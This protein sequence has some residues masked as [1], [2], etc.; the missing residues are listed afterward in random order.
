MLAIEMDQIGAGLYIAASV[1]VLIIV[2]LWVAVPFILLDIRR[3]ARR[4]NDQVEEALGELRAIAASARATSE[5]VKNGY[6]L[7]YEAEVRRRS[8]Q[9]QAEQGE[10]P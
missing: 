2:A 6:K 3:E 8:A 7:M 5:N 10:R 9:R 4:S 1:V